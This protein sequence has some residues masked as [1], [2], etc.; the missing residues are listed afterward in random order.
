MSSKQETVDEVMRITDNA[1]GEIMRSLNTV[2]QASDKQSAAL[3]SLVS[4]LN[5]EEEGSLG[6][7]VSSLA[8]ALDGMRA[9][10]ASV[11]SDVRV[12]AENVQKMGEHGR[13]VVSLSS[14]I[15]NVA[16]A[17]RLLA[18]NAR[19]EASKEFSES[20]LRVLAQEM[21]SLSEE[22][23]GAAYRIEDVT[24]AILAEVPQ[25]TGK[26]TELA[27][28]CED[29]VKRAAERSDGLKG[30][31]EDAKNRTSSI[32]ESSCEITSQMRTS[33]LDIIGQLAFADVIRQKLKKILEAG[34]VSSQPTAEAESAPKERHRDPGE[35]ILF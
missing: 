33:N 19:I 1:V 20:A 13:Q 7:A 22:V 32:A 27:H 26:A 24:D 6:I 35:I 25:I 5:S 9:F 11:G 15:R 30:A 14:Q 2:L 10:M 34:D 23:D 8:E 16:H 4:Q 21:K 28:Q 12:L 3:A 17:S 29:S 31:L 18:L